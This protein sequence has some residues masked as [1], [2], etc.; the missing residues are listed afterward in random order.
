MSMMRCSTYVRPGGRLA[1]SDIVALQEIPQAVRGDLEAYAGCASGAA[2]VA[3]V[4]GMLRD[5]GFHGVRVDLKH[6]SRGSWCKTGRQAREIS[7][8]PR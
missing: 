4:E 7:S 2:L 5:A 6:E 3:E 1:I 8:L